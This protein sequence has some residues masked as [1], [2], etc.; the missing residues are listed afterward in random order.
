MVVTVT[1][2]PCIDRTITIERLVL[3]GT[4]KVVESRSDISGKGVNVST[5]LHNLGMETLCMGFNFVNGS[6]PLKSFLDEQG[7]PA[8]LINVEGP[9][10]T[11]TKIFDRTSHCMTEYNEGGTPVSPEILAKFTEVLYNQLRQMGMCDLLVLDGS[12]PPGV[13]PNFYQHVIEEAKKSGVRTV[14]DA[15]GSLLREGIVAAPYA[16]KPNL[17]ELEEL[18]GRPLSTAKAVYTVTEELLKCGIRYICVSLGSDGAMLATPHGYW[19]VP[20]MEDI[21]IRGLQGAGDSLVAGMCIGISKNLPASEI[22]QYAEAAA[23]ASVCQ[24]GTLLCSRAA[25]EAFLPQITSSPI[26][27]KRSV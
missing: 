11:N 18:A 4:N 15:S 10:R 16:I 17:S 6:M 24:V 1:L 9:L 21:E 7:I 14:L 13:P 25:F 19:Y 23:S 5:A 12:V 27:G 26:K 8:R 3:N 22:L 2:N 20:A